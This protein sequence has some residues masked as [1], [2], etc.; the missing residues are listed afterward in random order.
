MAFDHK[1]F[2]A[3]FP[4][5]NQEVNGQPLVYLDNAASS[6]KPKEVIDAVSAY[7]L[8]D[9]AN[10]HRGVHTLSQRATDQFE[11]VR[12][13]IAAWINAPSDKEV[14]FTRGTTESINLVANSFGK[15]FIE[16]G[17]EVLISAMEHHS[18]IVPWQLMCDEWGAVLKVIPVDD[19][20]CLD[21]RAFD[22]I[23]SGKTRLVAVNHIS[24]S[25]GT[26][27][28]IEEIIEK[29]HKVAAAVLI[30]GAQA[31]P[32]APIDVQALDADFYCLSSHKMY[33]PTGM[34]ILYGKEYWLNDMPPYQGGGE[35]IDR[36]SF[37]GTTFNDLP[38]KFE[39]GTPNIADTIGFG[40]AID[41]LKHWDL[42]AMS[43]YEQELLEYGTAQLL[44]IEGLRIIGTAPKKASVI[45]F[46]V[47]DIHPFDMGTILD[48]LGIAVR[49]GHHCT[50][51]LMEQF[52]IP[53]TVRASFAAYN[54]KEEVDALVVGVKRAVSML[55]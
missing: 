18:N 45:S 2:R 48:Q 46:L 32:H 8:K 55:S 31:A 47:G 42:N 11:E 19:R 20:G 26:I 49:T 4:I 27:N 44:K 40:A 38:F 35:M 7:Y 5:L 16:E 12:R 36:V 50:M 53:G 17:D 28:P 9:H 1:A 41:F 37:E 51:P 54:T 52:Q 24:N 34:G 25:L 23:L 43:A 21:M 39:A 13:K 22:E 30:D 10:V 3:A 6:Q 29:A 14:I 33:G 15:A